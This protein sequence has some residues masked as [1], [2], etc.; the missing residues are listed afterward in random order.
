MMMMI[1]TKMA[2]MIN[3]VQLQNKSIFAIYIYKMLRYV[4]VHGSAVSGLQEQN[5]TY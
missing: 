4:S 1:M 2:M 3:H 5:R